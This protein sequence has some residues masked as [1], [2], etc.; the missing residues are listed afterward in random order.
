MAVEGK[1]GG[2]EPDPPW[3]NAGESAT[4][5]PP[6]DAGVSRRRFLGYG[7]SGLA[8]LLV[9]GAV[10]YGLKQEPAEA[11]A[12]APPP[13]HDARNSESTRPSPPSLQ[14]PV[15]VHPHRVDPAR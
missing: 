1:G 3:A 4:D 13:K 15:Q 6:T 12:V 9:G 8:G 2:S 11:P 14:W 7:G 5:H 10:G